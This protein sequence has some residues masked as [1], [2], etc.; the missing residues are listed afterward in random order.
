MVVIQRVLKGSGS[1]TYTTLKV[2]GDLIGLNIGH[3][4]EIYSKAGTLFL[5]SMSNCFIPD[6]F[7]LIRTGKVFTGHDKANMQIPAKWK[8][9]YIGEDQFVK[10]FYTRIGIFIKPYRGEFRNYVR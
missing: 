2:A 7:E 8:K 9:E 3:H 5:S 4:V 6:D 1:R 10:V